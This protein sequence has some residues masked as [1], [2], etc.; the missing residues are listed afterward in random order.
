VAGLAVGN[1]G[2]GS[3]DG[4]ADEPARNF[5]GPICEQSAGFSSALVLALLFCH[6][7]RRYYRP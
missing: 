5:T 3:G 2:V 4:D 6:C 1:Y 7:P